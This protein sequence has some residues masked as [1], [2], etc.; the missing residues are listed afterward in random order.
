M[1]TFW[2]AILTTQENLYYA[3]FIA[4][5]AIASVLFLLYEFYSEHDPYLVGIFQQL[6]IYIAT[7]FLLDFFLGLFATPAKARDKYLRYNLINLIS[8]IPVTSDFARALRILRLLR[9]LRVIRAGVDMWLATKRYRDL[10]RQHKKR[11]LP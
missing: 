7:L 8:S 9:A 2:K 3:F 11:R 1:K 6:D 10:K 4:V 5:L